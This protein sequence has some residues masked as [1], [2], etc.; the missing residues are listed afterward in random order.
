MLMPSLHSKYHDSFLENLKESQQPSFMTKERLIFGKTK[1]GYIF[2]SYISIQSMQSLNQG[3]QYV[4]TFRVEKN[5]RKVC[6]IYTDKEGSIEHISS[7][8]I[9]FLKID[10]KYISTNKVNIN[11]LFKNI[12]DDKATYMTKQGAQIQ[13]NP[14]NDLDLQTEETFDFNL[15]ISEINFSQVKEVGFVFKFEKTM[16]QTTEQNLNSSLAGQKKNKPQLSTFQFAMDPKELQIVGRYMDQPCSE[17]QS[18]RFDETAIIG[19]GALEPEQ[20]YSPACTGIH[21]DSRGHTHRRTRP[22][23]PTYTQKHSR[24][25]PTS[26]RTPS[27]TNDTL[28]RAPPAQRAERDQPGG[29]HQVQFAGR[30]TGGQA[31]RPGQHAREEELRRGNQDPAA[32]G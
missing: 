20:R 15:I 26:P 30:E 31:R 2:P 8:C 28:I 24:T 17:L 7:S 16:G 18:Q 4:A 6:Y 3:Y 29:E 32:A 27:L 23:T 19:F 14:P 1:S 25:A 11:D 10:N 5:F 21:T 12:L 13:Y 22:H 9:N